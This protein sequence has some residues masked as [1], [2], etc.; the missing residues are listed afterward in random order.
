MKKNILFL[1]FALILL[2]SCNKKSVPADNSTTSQETFTHPKAPKAQGTPRIL[3][4]GNSHTEYFVSTPILFSELCKA[5]NQLMDIDQLIT[6]GVSIDEI[7]ADHEAEAEQ[8][9]A[10][11]D[12][13]GNYYDYVIIQEST[14]VAIAE[15]DRYQENVKMIVKEIHK[16]SPDAALYIYEGMSP[17]AFTDPDYKEYYDEMR[18]NAISVM[19]NTKNAGLLRVGDA[20]NDAYN[21]KNG[22]KYLVGN[23][24]N[25]RYGQNT[26]HLLNDGGFMQAVLLYATIF[27][28]KPSIP[29]ELTLSTGTGDNDDM[30]KQDVNKAIS[31]P[32]ALEEIAFSNR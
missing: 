11:T 24:D 32:K 25:L 20:V 5:N 22:Y 3:F 17:I 7:Y 18:N 1:S 27:D 30:K 2:S 31:N 10:E 21:G 15:P 19:K 14:P 4:I 6:M 13:D 26:L 8:N 9:F 29:T 16:N 12:K 28:K 23:K